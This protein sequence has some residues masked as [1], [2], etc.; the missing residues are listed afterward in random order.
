MKLD[1]MTQALAEAD[2][3]EALLSAVSGAAQSLGFDYCAFGMRL[4]LPLSNPRVVMHSSYPSAWQQRYAEQNYLASDP[5][6]THALRSVPPAVWSEELFSPNLPLWEDARGH[7]LR[8]GWAQSSCD[9]QGA[10]GMLTLARTHDELSAAELALKAPY[11]TWLA[12]AAQAGM[13]RLAAGQPVHAQAA[14]PE[15]TA[16]ECEML[17]WTADG[18]TSG[19]I[20]Q[21]TGISERTV[22]FHLTNAV[23]KLGAANKTAAAVKAAVLR[24]L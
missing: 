16:R 18:K 9:A 22:N 10:V 3:G 4:P 21:I 12:H 2:S 1:E 5:T 23:G 15:L 11:M 24:L 6:V 14:L 19:E 8:V 17:R 7:G 13:A 20:A